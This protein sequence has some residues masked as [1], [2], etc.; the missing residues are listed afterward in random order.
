MPQQYQGLR[1]LLKMLSLVTS[2]VDHLN[3]W[4]WGPGIFFGKNPGFGY[5]RKKK[6][7]V[8]KDVAGFFEYIYNAFLYIDIVHVYYVPIW[9]LLSATVH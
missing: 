9:V 4:G 2:G 5:A 6:H 1:C 3:F 8:S 7:I